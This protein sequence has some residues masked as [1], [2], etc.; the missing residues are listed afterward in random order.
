MPAPVRLDD[1]GGVQQA[2]VMEADAPHA[3]L[4]LQPDRC[5]YLLCIGLQGRPPPLCELLPQRQLPPALNDTGSKRR[6]QQHSVHQG[7]QPPRL[8][9]YGFLLSV[10]GLYLAGEK[11]QRKE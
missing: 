1:A 5:P 10:S 9:R 11:L 2:A 4:G 8:D 6:V 3:H 7:A